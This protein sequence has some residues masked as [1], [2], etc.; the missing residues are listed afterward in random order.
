MARLT[1][2][3]EWGRWE[4]GR[5]GMGGREGKRGTV[6]RGKAASNALGGRGRGR[7]TGRAYTA[8][9]WRFGLKPP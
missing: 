4:E 5:K 2:G 1:R 9:Q 7:G 3:R 8:Y 6:G